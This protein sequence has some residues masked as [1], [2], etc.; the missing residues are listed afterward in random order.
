MDLYRHLE[1]MSIPCIQVTEACRFEVPQT[2]KNPYAEK[3]EP[4]P[5]VNGSKTLIL[6]SWCFPNAQSNKNAYLPA[7]SKGFQLTPK[8]CLIDTC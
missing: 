1:I 8:G 6:V 3:G 7:P 5:D 4:K 2:W